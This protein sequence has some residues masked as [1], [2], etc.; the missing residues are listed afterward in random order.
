MRTE[1]R[2]GEEDS[3]LTM[4][5]LVHSYSYEGVHLS[6]LAKSTP[7]QHCPCPALAAQVVRCY[8]YA[9]PPPPPLAVVLQHRQIVS[10]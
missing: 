9:P 7:P 2:G 10:G 3:S 5:E 6:S 8:L 1:N 4:R